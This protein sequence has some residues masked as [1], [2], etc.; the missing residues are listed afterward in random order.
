MGVLP[1]SSFDLK[2][3][4]VP[5]HRLNIINGQASNLADADINI[6]LANPTQQGQLINSLMVGLDRKYTEFLGTNMYN[7]GKFYFEGQLNAK[8][9][10]DSFDILNQDTGKEWDIDNVLDTKVGS[11][12]FL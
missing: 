1:W 8:N 11:F 3:F 2:N 7:L 12:S 10:G 4:V 5:N 6:N 9:Y